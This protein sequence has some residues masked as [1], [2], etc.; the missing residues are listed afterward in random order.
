MWSAIVRLH[1]LRLTFENSH[2]AIAAGSQ[3]TSNSSV[4]LR[5]VLGD[6]MVLLREE[7]PGSEKLAAQK[8][9]FL[10]ANFHWFIILIGCWFHPKHWWIV[11]LLEGPAVTSWSI[12]S[13][14]QID[15]RR[16]MIRHDTSTINPSYPPVI[17]HGTWTSPIYSLFPSYEPPLSW[18]F[19]IFHLLVK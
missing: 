18:G 8:Y 15:H 19:S 4:R 12:I 17:K 11:V 5:G 9:I 14:T 16:I 3:T 10:L 7:P 13:P 6:L 1:Q 2:P